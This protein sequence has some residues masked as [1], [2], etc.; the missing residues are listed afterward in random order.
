[1]TTTKTETADIVK[2]L[3]QIDFTFWYSPV[4]PDEKFEPI[5]IGKLSHEAANEIVLLRKEIAD[6]EKI[7]EEEK[8]A[9]GY[10]ITK[11]V[12]KKFGAWNPT[13]EETE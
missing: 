6:L 8:C 13:V 11:R 1:M 12:L 3:R 5:E 7:M 9:L 2:R 10:L 4:G